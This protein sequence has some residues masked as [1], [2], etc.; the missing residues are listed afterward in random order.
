MVGDVGCAVYVRSFVM[1]GRIRSV[2]VRKHEQGEPAGAGYA[3]PSVHRPR[4]IALG[5][6]WL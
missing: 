6:N 1:L 2:H 5:E 4:W 3:E